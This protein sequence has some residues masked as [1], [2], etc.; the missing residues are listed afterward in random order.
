MQQNTYQLSITT[1]S[2][3][4]PRLEDTPTYNNHHMIEKRHS[5]PQLKPFLNPTSSSLSTKSANSKH[6]Y[7]LLPSNLCP[8][9]PPTNNN[10]KP[11]IDLATTTSPNEEISLKDLDRRLGE[12]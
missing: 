3:E 6:N 4:S 2:H 9:S 7:T 10:L 12:S 1:T 5:L 8:P 11:K